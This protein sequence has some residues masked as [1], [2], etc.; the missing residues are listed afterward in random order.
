MTAMTIGRLASAADVKIDTVRYYERSGLLAPAARRESGYRE[1][2]HDEL[3][4]LRFIR[5]A[6]QLGFSLDEIRELLH[7]VDSR[8]D[9]AEV[10]ALAEDRLGDIERRLEQLTALRDT[11]RDL[12]RACHGHG[13]L[14]DCPIIEAVVDGDG[15]PS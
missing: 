1:Y 15:R 10:R 8:G 14:S 2:G 11:L 7:L 3:Q 13:D 4:R 5:R 9:R 6:Q 12:V